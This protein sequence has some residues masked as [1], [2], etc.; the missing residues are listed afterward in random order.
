MDITHKLFQRFSI[1]SQ[2]LASRQGH[3][4]IEV[5][6]EELI[7]GNHEAFK[8]VLLPAIQAHS[9]TRRFIPIVN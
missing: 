6:V 1:G 5:E 8:Y 9:Q 2:W 7:F 4:G 3:I